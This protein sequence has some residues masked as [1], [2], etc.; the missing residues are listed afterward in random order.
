M[1][2]KLNQLD[3]EFARDHRKLLQ[4]FVLHET[5]AQHA[6]GLAKLLGFIMRGAR[7]SWLLIAIIHFNPA[8]P[9]SHHHCS[10]S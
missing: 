2:L 7:C 4:A 9:R 1:K 10:L 8:L 6:S 5:S 3:N